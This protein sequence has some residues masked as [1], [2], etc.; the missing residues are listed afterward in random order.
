MERLRAAQPRGQRLDGGAHDVVPGLLRGKRAS[1]C[2]RVEAAMPGARVLCSE[3][4]AHDLGPQFPRR[5]ILGDL[6]KKIVV[7]IE[8][9]R[10]AWCELIH[11]KASRDRGG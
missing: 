3:A 1:G 5:A 8:E 9:K 10:Q 2:L 7:G 6:L 11:R 4:V